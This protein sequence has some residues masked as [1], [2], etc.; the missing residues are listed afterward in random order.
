MA[1]ISLRRARTLIRKAMDHGK[2]NDMKPLSAVVLDA[3]GHVIAFERADGT[4]PGRF[5]LAHGKAYGA[6]MLG[7]G[8]SGLEER[9]E[10]MPR[11][12]D[13]ASALFGGQFVPLKGGVLIKDAKG[14]TLGALGVTGD[15]PDNDAA[16]GL[17]A[18]ESVGLV[19]EA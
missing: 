16:A 7:V 2:E 5:P 15:S 19:G 1:T 17:A 13:S 6:I 11:F 12:I 10:T 3:G 14:A 8:G 9:A 4:P 18:V